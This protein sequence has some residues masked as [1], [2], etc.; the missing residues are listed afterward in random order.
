MPETFVS[1]LMVL[2]AGLAGS[3]ESHE[4]LRLLTQREKTGRQLQPPAASHS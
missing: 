1:D 3:I 4:E 2:Q